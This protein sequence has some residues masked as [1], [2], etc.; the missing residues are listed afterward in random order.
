MAKTNFT[1]GPI[2]KTNKYSEMDL[3]FNKYVFKTLKLE[4]HLGNIGYVLLS[5]KLVCNANMRSFNMSK[6]NKT[7]AMEPKH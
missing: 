1:L 5:Q 2:S 4:K 6:G 3:D 7:L